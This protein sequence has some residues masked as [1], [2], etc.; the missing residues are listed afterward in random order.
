MGAFVRQR[1]NSIGFG[2]SPEEALEDAY[3]NAC[4]ANIASDTTGVFNRRRSEIHPWMPTKY[5]LH[6]SDIGCLVYEN[7]RIREVKSGKEVIMAATDNSM[8]YY[9]AEL[10]ENRLSYTDIV[11]VLREEIDT[12]FTNISKDFIPI[13]N[14]PIIQVQTENDEFALDVIY[15]TSLDF[16]I[17][18][19][20][21]MIGIKY[22]G[23]DVYY[24]CPIVSPKQQIG[25]LHR[26]LYRTGFAFV[27]DV[28][29]ELPEVIIPKQ[30]P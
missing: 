6:L 3:I 1:Y 25:A 21:D 28:L 4:S 27:D 30:D 18:C 8:F 19:T 2:I 23:E 20:E 17:G 15:R 29:L 24:T 16:T 5:M 12:F 11:C 26:L 9:L 22:V 13:K 10:F 14:M 7:A